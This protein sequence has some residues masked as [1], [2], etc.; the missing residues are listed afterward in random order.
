MP[1]MSYCRFE[2]TGGDLRDCEE[3]LEDGAA[4]VG[5]DVAQR[6]TAAILDQLIAEL[7]P[8]LRAIVTGI[9]E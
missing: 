7:P 4:D 1:N 6:E 5:R 8:H 9:T 3:A 2:N